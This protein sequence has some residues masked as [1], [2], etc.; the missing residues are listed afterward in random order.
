MVERGEVGSRREEG[1]AKEEGR[2]K[3]KKDV[4]IEAA[5]SVPWYPS[6]F[7]CSEHAR[8]DHS[9]AFSSWVQSIGIVIMVADAAPCCYVSC[10][11]QIKSEAQYKQAQLT[12]YMTFKC[13]GGNEYVFFSSF[14]NADFD[15]QICGSIL[16][17]G[18]NSYYN[19]VITR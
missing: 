4:L 3:R 15:L 11:S 2:K 12:N 7:P 17:I 5:E 18:S 1:R 19:S 16:P 8:Q 6:S 10:Y 9:Q 14:R 13:M